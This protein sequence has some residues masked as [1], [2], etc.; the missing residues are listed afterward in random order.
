MLIK[1]I[2]RSKTLACVVALVS[3]VS[4]SSVANASTI[5]KLGSSDIVKNWPDYV[6]FGTI[7]DGSSTT[8]NSENA[9]ISLELHPVNS[10]FMYEN[11]DMTQTDGF[12]LLSYPY[13]TYNLI[14][15][16]DQLNDYDH[17]PN[18]GKVV[19][20]T[21]FYTTNLSYSSYYQSQISDTFSENGLKNMFV[22]LILMAKQYE[23]S[24]KENKGYPGGSIILSPDFLPNLYK[25]DTTSSDS[26]ET[27]LQEI[28]NELSKNN[29]VLT[30][31]L[32]AAI[33]Q[34]TKKE[35]FDTSNLSSIPN[36]NPGA[37]KKYYNSNAG[38]MV[39]SCP[40]SYTNINISTLFNDLSENCFYDAF[41]ASTAWNYIIDNQNNTQ[42]NTISSSNSVLNTPNFKDNVNGYIQAINWAIKTYAPD[43]SFG[44]EEG[45][46]SYQGDA[47]WLHDPDVSPLKAGAVVG[48]Q[49]Q[50]LGV[51]KGNY[52]PDFIVFDRYSIDDFNTAI[53]PTA[54]QPHNVGYTYN[55][56]DWS[57]Y[58][59]FV[60]AVSTYLG[61]TSGGKDIPV[62]LWQEP[63]GHIQLNDK[64]EVDYRD[65]YG[66]DFTNYIFGSYFGAQIIKSN[67]SNIEPYIKKISL[68]TNIYDNL[69]ENG[70]TLE[71][72]L[73][74]SPNAD[75]Y[76]YTWNQQHISH[77]AKGEGAN[78]VDSHV[79]A[80]LFG[81]AYETGVA[82]APLVDTVGYD[83]GWLANQIGEYYNKL[84]T[85]SVTF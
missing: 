41:D 66:S 67:M 60:K 22:K 44:W 11:Q 15:E 80:V 30:S 51:Y 28:N 27:F 68:S 82:N 33:Q 18:D 77:N 19:P 70:E 8:T 45:I 62:M 13:V 24:Y 58:L 29:N 42:L 74:E 76:N 10:V 37:I 2:Y 35:N 17:Y 3:I 23:N 48:K 9:I 63:G 7:T 54:I 64:S 71:T 39:I 34:I 26:T 36:I 75:N 31:S 38:K 32:N 73:Q 50:E 57:R 20:V 21:V 6:S 5:G 53:Q 56:A 61:L 4:Y 16:T 65:N 14:Q 78:L 59:K 49:L 84:Q 40:S 25:I 83:G 47:N 72:Y 81:Q 52:R 69:K 1:R 12:G 43:V 79:F 85:G 55:A 46:W